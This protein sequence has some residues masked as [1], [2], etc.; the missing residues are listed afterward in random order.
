MPCYDTS[1][2][3]IGVGSHPGLTWQQA[4]NSIEGSAMCQEVQQLREAGLIAEKGC[5]DWNNKLDSPDPCYQHL[6]NLTQVSAGC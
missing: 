6:D 4:S 2:V 5:V 3:V 1:D